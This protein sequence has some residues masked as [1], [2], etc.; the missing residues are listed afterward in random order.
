MDTPEHA[1]TNLV[2]EIQDSEIYKSLPDEPV[3][4]YNEHGDSVVFIAT[5]ED[6]IGEWVDNH[7]T[8][9]RSAVNREQVIGFKIKDVSALA[10]EFDCDL[11]VVLSS[12]SKN[13]HG[14]IDIDFLLFAAIQLS[15]RQKDREAVQGY[16]LAASTQSMLAT[17]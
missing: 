1:L 10:K 6:T 12:Y 3:P 17:S 4:W 13:P 8:L 2:A 9:Y 15:N 14:G 7:L 5:Q 11:S 16:I